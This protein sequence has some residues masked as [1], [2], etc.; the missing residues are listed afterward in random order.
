[1]QPLASPALTGEGVWQPTGREVAGLPAVY[2]TSF[3]PDAVHTSYVAGAMWMDTTLLKSVYVPGLQEPGGSTPQAWGAQIPLDRRSSLVAAF[4]SGF[5]LEAALGGVFTDGVTVKPLVDGK[6]SFVIDKFGKAS[7]GAWGRDFTM[8]ANIATVRQNLDLIVDNGQPA[9]GL[10]DNADGAWGATVGNR[11]FVWRSGVGVDAHGGLIYVAGP[12]LS[13]VTLAVLL[14]RAGAVR[15]MELDINPDWTT[16]YYFTSDNPNP[17]LVTGN[18]LLP[19]MA[20]A[21]DRYLQ[22]GERDFHVMIAAI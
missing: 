22:P 19:D 2:T 20:R 1:M 9:P 14:Q 18:K 4:N 13:A 7:V 6:A 21:G 5:K 15:A 16:A 17:A 11:T 12:S 10:P 8:S 3:R